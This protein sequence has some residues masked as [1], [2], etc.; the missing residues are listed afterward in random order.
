METALAAALGF[1]VPTNTDGSVT[2][3]SIWLGIQ[4]SQTVNDALVKQI[5]TH[6][7]DEELGTIS[8][9][10]DSAPNIIDLTRY[11]APGVRSYTTS[12]GTH[13]Y[14]SAD[15][16]YMGPEYFQYFASGVR[17]SGLDYGDFDS[18]N[19]VQ[20]YGTGTDVA[21]AERRMLNTAGWA[22][23]GPS[24]MNQTDASPQNVLPTVPV[25]NV[26]TAAGVIP[27]ASG[28][29]VKIIEGAGSGTVTLASATTVVNTLQNTATA[30]A[31]TVNLA[32]QQLVA[33]NGAVDAGV[34]LIGIN[35]GATSLTIGSS[36]NDGTVT[37]GTSGAYTLGLINAGGNASVLDIRSAIVDNAGSGSV[38]VLEL[39]TGK[40]IFEGT[41]TYTGTTTVGS[42]STLQIGNGGTTGSFGAG[43]VEVDGTLVFD[44]G[45]ASPVTFGNTF[46]GAG[47]MTQVGRPKSS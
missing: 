33:G 45:D 10:G 39:N 38:S 41:N 9:V 35:A 5:F 47:A 30:T 32:G 42:G 18:S 22:Y 8:G 43:N 26:S 37:A 14:F 17:P 28:N 25:S 23:T 20:G 16:T 12:T 3:G 4:G 15:G 29:D 21:T 27:N 6:E 46:T 11:S 44:R 40:V 24:V 13:A 1:S 36:V 34:G 2:S 31:V 7:M 19:L